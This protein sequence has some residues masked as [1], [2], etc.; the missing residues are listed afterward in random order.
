MNLIAESIEIGN[1]LEELP[2]VNFSHHLLQ[3]RAKTLFS[4]NQ[5]DIEKVKIAFEFVR[6]QIA[7]SLDIESRYVPCKASDVLKYGEGVCFAKANLLAALLR[8]QTIPTGFCYQRLRIKNITETRFALHALNA[9]FIPSVG[10]WIRLDA[11]GNKVGLQSEF[12]IYE[13]KLPYTPD[14]SLG[15]MDYPIIYTKPNIEAM[16]VLERST[17]A[18]QMYRHDLPSVINL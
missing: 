5:S 16:A 9:V 6:D 3:K 1:Y 2:V 7:Q 8:S 17:D 12:S 13:E 18:L 14:E 4:D 15:E 10:R 11:R